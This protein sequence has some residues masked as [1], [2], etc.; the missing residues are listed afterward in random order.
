MWQTKNNQ[1]PIKIAGKGTLRPEKQ[2]GV[3][4][5]ARGY[6]VCRDSRRTGAWQKG[7][8]WGVLFFTPSPPTLFSRRCE[9]RLGNASAI[10]QYKLRK[11]YSAVGKTPSK[12]YQVRSPCGRLFLVVFSTKAEGEMGQ[13]GCG[14]RAHGVGIK[15]RVSTASSLSSCC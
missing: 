1:Y 9:K 13:W 3:F 15:I 7:W 14:I 6:F 12:Q 10:G 2:V 4:F 8:R 5:G 11:Q